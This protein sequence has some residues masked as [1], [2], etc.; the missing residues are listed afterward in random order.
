MDVGFSLKSYLNCTQD[1]FNAGKRCNHELLITDTLHVFCGES[2]AH[3]G[4]TKSRPTIPS[5]SSNLTEHQSFRPLSIGATLARP[6]NKALK[7]FPTPIAYPSMSRKILAIILASLLQLASYGYGASN[8]SCKPARC[9]NLIVTYPFSLGGA[10]P[11]YCGF[12]SFELTCDGGRAYLT[13]TFQEH[14]YRVDDISYDNN[15]AVVAVEATFAGDETCRIPD[16]NVSSGL[17]LLPF[18]ISA[19]NSELTF[20]YNCALPRN[21]SVL[22]SPPCVNQAMGAYIPDDVGNA[23]VE[24]PKN[25]S[26]VVVPVR[27]FRHGMVPTRDYEQLINGGFLLQWPSVG[28]CNECTQRGGECRF[29]ALAFR[30]TCPDGLLCSSGKH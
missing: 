27:G 4:N 22:L 3:K 17:A 14:L 19:T 28:E 2:H 26:S 18:N 1:S 20:V 23:P 21:S 11:L 30:C 24:V 8:T 9:G 13:R 16:F 12:P 5:L 7:V 15:S 29:V 10:Q 6:R 25:C